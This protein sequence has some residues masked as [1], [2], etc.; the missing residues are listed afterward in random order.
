M[1][2]SLFHAHLPLLSTWSMASS[3]KELSFT[4]YLVVTNLNSHVWLVATVLDSTGFEQEAKQV[5]ED[6]SEGQGQIF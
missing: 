3:A 4:L 2:I 1:G 5:S 6:L